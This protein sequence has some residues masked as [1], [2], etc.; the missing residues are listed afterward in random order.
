MQQYGRK[1]WTPREGLVPCSYNVK[2]VPLVDPKQVLLPPLHIKLGLM[3]NFVKALYAN[4]NGLYYLVEKFPHISA[5]KMNAG[6]LIGPQIWE[7]M[8]NHK[9][10]RCLVGYEKNAWESFKLIMKNFLGNHISPDY[11]QVVHELL[12]NMQA[13]GSRMSK[14]HFLYSHLDYFPSNCGDYSED[15]GE[16]FFKTLCKWRIAIKEDG[17]CTWWWTTPVAWKEIIQ[18]PFTGENPSG[19]HSTQQSRCLTHR[20]I[21]ES[22][23]KWNIIAYI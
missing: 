6:I 11:E 18:K 2:A 21:L 15:Q 9:F 16:C 12:K 14:M 5:A 4:N 17:M 3:K 1:D 23:E 22:S 13:L 10:D 7:L 19:S 20:L 8:W